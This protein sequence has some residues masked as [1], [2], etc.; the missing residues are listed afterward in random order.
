[1]KLL[2]LTDGPIENP[3][4]RIRVHQFLPHLE[5]EGW[6][7]QIVQAGS[8]LPMVLAGLERHL[9]GALTPLLRGSLFVLRVLNRGAQHVVG[10]AAM[11]RAA[12]SDTDVVVVCCVAP[13]ARAIRALQQ[14]GKAVAFDLVDAVWNGEHVAHRRLHGA[15]T[16][17]DLVTTASEET[18]TYVR[19]HG[20]REVMSLVGPIDCNRYRPRPIAPRQEVII[21]WVGSP[22]T[23]RYL[24]LVDKPLARVCRRHPEVRVRLLGASA[25]DAPGVP[26]EH[27][28]WRLDDEPD[29]IATFDL[30]I[31]PQVD[32]AWGR[33]KGGYKLLQYMACGR[34]AVCSPVGAAASI[35]RHGE[36]G[37]HARTP[38]EWE[39]ALERL[40]GDACLRE[41][42]GRR[43]REIAEAEYSFQVTWP[44]LR[45][46]L[47]RIVATRRKVLA[48]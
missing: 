36:T 30:G 11:T 31:M 20:G 8:R 48:A 22:T 6:Q 10:L 1:M 41:R 21:G 34:P 29:V 3:Q 5:R 25:F 43:G 47:R 13:S 32:D 2:Y 38:A 45:D 39:G 33:G 26:V 12:L 18:A 35:V 44:R 46:T 42:M 23:T 27:V 7:W 4:P 37:L 40:V 28:P 9:P 24:S 15:L 19:A 14:R 16:T 17:V